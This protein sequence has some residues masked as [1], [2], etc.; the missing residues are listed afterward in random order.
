MSAAESISDSFAPMLRNRWLWLPLV[1]LILTWVLLLLLYAAI[2]SDVQAPDSTTVV[3]AV[4]VIPTQRPP[5]VSQAMELLRTPPPPPPDAPPSLAGSASP[6]PELPAMAVS[7]VDVGPITIPTGAAIGQGTSLGAAGHFGG[8]AS[9]SGSG[10]GG[11]GAGSGGGRWKGKPLV[12]LSTARPQMPEWACKE[13]ISGWVEAVF[14]V[15]LN[16]RVTSVKIV[17]AEPRGVFEAAAIESISNWLY[18]PMGAA[19]EV[20]QRVPMDPAD[21]A[22][23]WLQ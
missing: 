1:A 5:P 14:T 20:R 18:E 15:G 4:R 11:G 10:S 12:P 17:D 2:H 8:F 9:G 23:N 7:T 6:A 22:Y 13:K 16:G 3:E 21:C 19:M